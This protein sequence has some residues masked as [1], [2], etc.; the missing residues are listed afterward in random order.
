M[1]KLTCLFACV[2]LLTSITFP[3]RNT[4]K[5]PPNI[6]FILAED[7][8]RKRVSSHVR[9]LFDTQDIDQLTRE[10]V[11]FTL[12]STIPYCTPTRSELLTGRYPFATNTSRVIYDYDQHSDMVLDV[13]EPSFAW[14]F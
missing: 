4:E 1:K 3:G 11:M 10:G 5:K 2:V 12:A 7:R 8:G 13:S 9:C 6:L 14:Q